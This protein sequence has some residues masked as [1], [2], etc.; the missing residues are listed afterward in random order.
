MR[1]LATTPE[2]PVVHST[3]DFMFIGTVFSVDV[4]IEDERLS[5]ERGD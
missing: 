1:V 2:R 4:L 3:V 5:L